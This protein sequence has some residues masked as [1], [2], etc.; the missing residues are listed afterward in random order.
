MIG[1][2]ASK[3]GARS[4]EQGARERVDMVFDR[5]AGRQAGRQGRVC[6]WASKGKGRDRDRG[7][8]D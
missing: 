6:D 3:Q 5:L 2:Q 1:W 8:I 7:R 4:K